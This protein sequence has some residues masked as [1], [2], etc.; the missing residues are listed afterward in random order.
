[1]IEHEKCYSTDEE[2]FDIDNVC[3]VFDELESNGKLKAGQCYWVADAVKQ[4]PSWYFSVDN[5]LNNLTESAAD[6]GGGEYA[7]YFPNVSSDEKAELNKLIC[8]WLDAKVAVTFYNVE[9]PVEIEIT[10]AD[11]DDY[12]K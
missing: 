8:D 9:H 3:D 11:I 5:L 6:N 7:E 10:Q 4:K 2:S 1:M 12:R